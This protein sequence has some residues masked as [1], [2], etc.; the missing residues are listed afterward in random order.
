M[1]RDA[2]IICGREDR[3][4]DGP[5]SGGK[6]SKSESCRASEFSNGA[7]GLRSMHRGHLVLSDS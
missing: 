7:L 1:L 6:G 4:L 5:A 2:A 3:V